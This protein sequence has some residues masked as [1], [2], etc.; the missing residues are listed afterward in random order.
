M[1][2]A[3]IEQGQQDPACGQQENS[4]ASSK[5]DVG[6]KTAA[7]DLPCART[8]KP[9]SLATWKTWKLCRPQTPTATPEVY[10]VLLPT[11]KYVA[12]LEVVAV[13]L[14]FGVTAQ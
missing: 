11:A 6:G 14:H 12:I 7:L 8:T 2:T 3:K 13:D 10:S 5:S 9:H 4:V 1:P